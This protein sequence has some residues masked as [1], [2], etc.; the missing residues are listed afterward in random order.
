MPLVRLI[1]QLSREDE[2]FP[3]CNYC[4]QHA[5]ILFF[6]KSLMV[7]RAL[8]NSTRLS[9]PCSEV[10]DVDHRRSLISLVETAARS[11]SPATGRRQRNASKFCSDKYY[12]HVCFSMIDVV[13][14]LRWHS[15]VSPCRRERTQTRCCSH[16][17]YNS[18]TYRYTASVSICRANKRLLIE[19]VL[20]YM[21]VS[22]ASRV[23]RGAGQR[24]IGE[25]S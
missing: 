19:R 12:I 22:L 1:P 18:H 14:Q 15:L 25:T 8:G 3:H 21:V 4:C 10:S 20:Q 17:C 13:H 6:P 9:V 11:G 5:A 2:V 7:S 16:T 23:K 24:K